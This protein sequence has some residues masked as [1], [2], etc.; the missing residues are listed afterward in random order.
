MKKS[1]R[2]G[3]L[4]CCNWLKE[5]AIL[6]SSTVVA[7]I[8]FFL[9]RY[10]PFMKFL[11]SIYDILCNNLFEL[12][13][14]IFIL[15][16]LTS[17]IVYFLVINRS[18]LCKF[19][20][21]RFP[22]PCIFFLHFLI[23]R[24]RWI[25][26]LW[27]ML[28]GDLGRA[29]GLLLALSLTLSLLFSALC[30]NYQI[31]PLKLDDE[32]KNISNYS[33]SL[34]TDER[35]TLEL[36][37]IFTIKPSFCRA[38][39][40]QTSL[41]RLL[42]NSTIYNY[43]STYPDLP[44]AIIKTSKDLNETFQDETKFIE[45]FSRNQLF[46]ATVSPWIKDVWIKEKDHSIAKNFSDKDEFYSK[47]K[48]PKNFM[49]ALGYDVVFKAVTNV[50]CP[51]TNHTQYCK[52]FRDK[53][54]NKKY[55]I[56]EI[57]NNS[58]DESLNI[59]FYNESARVLSYVSISSQ[60]P[61]I[62]EDIVKAIYWKIKSRNEFLNNIT[63][64]RISSC[65]IN[66]SCSVSGV[67]EKDEIIEIIRDN[68]TLRQGVLESIFAN[69]ST[70]DA[71]IAVTLNDSE[72]Q[73][74]LLNAQ[75][76]P[77]TKTYF[78]Y[79]AAF[80]W[81]YQQSLIFLWIVLLALIW[82]RKAGKSRVVAEFADET[83]DSGDKPKVAAGYSTLLVVKLNRLSRIYR[84]VDE[85][86]PISSVAIME[87][88]LEPTMRVEEG[89]LSTEIFTDDSKLTLGNFSIPGR[90]INSFID[91]LARRPKLYGSLLMDG[92]KEILTARISENG[93]T[94]S[95]W[96]DG[97]E[98]LPSSEV[99]SDQK[100]E[101]AKKKKT[102]DEMVNELAC[103]IF[104]DLT[105]DEAKIVPWKATWHF[106]EG[107]RKYREV[108]NAKS[109]Y[110]EMLEDAERSF[111]QSIQED[112][113]YPWAHYNL[114]VVYRMMGFAHLD[115]MKK[116]N[117][118]VN[119]D[120]D[121][122]YF[123]KAKKAFCASMERYPQYWQNYYSLAATLYRLCK[124]DK[125][126]NN[127]DDQNNRKKDIKNIMDKVKDLCSDCYSLAWIYYLWAEIIET[128]IIDDM[129]NA[130]N[131]FGLAS[132][133]ALLSLLKAE[134][135]GENTEAENHLCSLCLSKF[136]KSSSNNEIKKLAGEIS[137]QISITECEDSQKED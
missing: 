91:R 128:V 120:S 16:I 116:A 5:K 60:Y 78:L 87:K 3:V 71:S 6:I 52:N 55:R 62:R 1:W 109:S 68:Q 44:Q 76:A 10:E 100:D 83:S 108:L 63:D 25:G 102:K 119:R 47:F 86:M 18:R 64:E 127:K 101:N 13:K 136:G 123:E 22:V 48:E 28:S 2:D 72:L 51:K 134:F 93:R 37:R 4:M 43:T 46:D 7:L 11:G 84:Q 41:K 30:L 99:R 20:A 19:L 38:F 118:E 29:V 42:S 124:I 112:D 21:K 26:R 59:T 113:D 130:S 14:F 111:L 110:M 103:K 137:P 23:A 75:I 77:I 94:L 90:F 82:L 40:E 36:I 49:A 33:V 79:S 34:P 135:S 66:L 73:A 70:L 58:F 54:N 95:W 24:V 12:L 133:Y 132:Y 117:R 122:E 96:V 31:D 80:I 89:D 57:F 27:R 15:L 32:V 92:N 45:T 17:F 115:A 107:L 106:T 53:N 85:A 126:V 61:E 98:K 56:N 131:S 8:I 125:K 35:Q 105:F 97:Q 114:G 9:L 129:D 74:D 104:T 65:Y 67:E 81:S 121:K 50:L 39:S 69:K 88:K